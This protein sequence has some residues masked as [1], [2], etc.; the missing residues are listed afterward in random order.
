M[1]QIREQSEHNAAK[2][3]KSETGHQEKVASARLCQL[4]DPRDANDH[5]G[6]ETQVG[7]CASDGVKNHSIAS[8]NTS[9][10][11]GRSG[12]E[13]EQNQTFLTARTKENII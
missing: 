1:E 2:S 4:D 10:E 11:A 13:G 9:C 3:E 7:E 8:K 5:Q 6:S 12:E